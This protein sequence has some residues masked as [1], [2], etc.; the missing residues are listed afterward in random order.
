M[1]CE[2]TA[3]VIVVNKTVFTC[4]L[5]LILCIGNSFKEYLDLHTAKQTFMAFFVFGETAA[6]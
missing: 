2:L 4:T 3:P 1:K 6:S 5:V